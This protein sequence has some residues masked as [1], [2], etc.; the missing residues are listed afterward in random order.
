M[1]V[2]HEAFRDAPTLER[3]LN[4]ALAALDA[5]IAALEARTAVTVL[6]PRVV[7]LPVNEASDPA[8]VV[9]FSLPPGV[10][11]GVPFV[12]RLEAETGNTTIQPY[13]AEFRVTGDAVVV[14]RLTTATATGV[15]LLLTLGVTHGQ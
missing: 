9:S 13:A 14:T 2:R 10:V 7:T 8:S 11:P 5:R 6:G 4:D 15:R 12:L 3:P 1:R